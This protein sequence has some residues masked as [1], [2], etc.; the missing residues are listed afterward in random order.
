MNDRFLAALRKTLNHLYDPDFLWA[1]PLAEWLGIANEHDSPT[2]LQRLL[3]E[4]VHELR[5]KMS[6]RSN[7]R[8]WNTYELLSYRY[9]QQLDQKEIARQLGISL[10]QVKRDQQAA[11]KV[12]ASHLWEKYNIAAKVSLP[13]EPGAPSG[14]D[15][16]AWLAASSATATSLS[17]TYQDVQSMAG[18]LL[19]HHRVQLE[20]EIAEDVPCVAVH[21]TSLRQILLCLLTSAAQAAVGGKVVLQ[22]AARGTVA[23][24]RLTATAPAETATPLAEEQRASLDYAGRLARLSGGT[25]EV[26]TRP[27]MVAVELSLP[28]C[29]SVTVLAIDD[30]GD[31]LQLF[32]RYL[33]DTR[34]RLVTSQ[35]PKAVLEQANAV[36][37][38]VILLDIMM[39][40]I[41]GWMMLESL[42][43][44]PATA[45]TPIIVCSNIP[46]E[47]LAITL[48][49][50]AFLRKPISREKLLETIDRCL[51]LDN[52]G[53]VE[54]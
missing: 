5:P 51:T 41:D 31:T 4:A 36:Q 28:L 46:Q 20:S 33:Q 12:L 40:N 38:A 6:D 27:G 9:L 7:S 19:T 21:L 14:E 44:H 26:T 10:S 24:V 47:E 11:L 48:G 37:P 35:N 13:S 8:T 39:P 22:A 54:C 43:R 17:Q 2:R 45:A 1:S 53:P 32:D 49:A 52:D 3:E 42:R 34:F 16:L 23:R 29:L 25:L 50:Q 15:D 18:A 30:S